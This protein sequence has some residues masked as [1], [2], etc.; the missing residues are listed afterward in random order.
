MEEN[1]FYALGKRDGFAEVLVESYGNK[2]KLPW[3]AELYE[4]MTGEKHF[5]HQFHLEK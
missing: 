2:V 1:D 4:K 5:S 3:L